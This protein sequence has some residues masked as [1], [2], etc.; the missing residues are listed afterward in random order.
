MNL[1]ACIDIQPRSTFWNIDIVEALVLDL[2]QVFRVCGLLLQQGKI[3][4]ADSHS[5]K[6]KLDKET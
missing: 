1:A 5:L 6:M 3:K 4:D 2:E